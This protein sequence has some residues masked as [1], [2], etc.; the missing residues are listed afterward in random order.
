MADEKSLQDI[1]SGDLFANSAGEMTQVLN[2]FHSHGT[3]LTNKQ[4]AGIAFLNY[5]DSRSNE[6]AFKSITQALTM[7]SKDLTDPKLY[8]D[9]VDKMTLGDRIKGNVRM[10]KVFGNSDGK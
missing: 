3:P 8:L 2:F 7:H 6:K 1:M 5:L 4:V 9:V 10:A